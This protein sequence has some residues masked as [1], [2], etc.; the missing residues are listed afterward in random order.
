[1]S[2]SKINFVENK[3]KKEIKGWMG[4]AMSTGGRVTKTNA[5]LSNNVVYQM[6]LSLLHKTN[7]EGLEKPIRDFMRTC[8]GGKRRY[9][10]VKWKH[11]CKQSAKVA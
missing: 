9:H 7:I 4:S 11:I 5:C 1:M 6:S 10:L 2:G 8:N 3:M